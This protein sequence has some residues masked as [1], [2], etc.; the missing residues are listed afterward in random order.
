ME[1]CSHAF[2]PFDDHHAMCSR[3]GEIHYIPTDVERK[4]INRVI[5]LE[6]KS[7]Q[8]MSRDNK[9]SDEPALEHGNTLDEDVEEVEKKLIMQ[10]LE[11][12]RY[13]KT[14]AAGLLGITFRSY[15]W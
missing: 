8:I 7:E 5:E 9:E 11:D 6:E 14:Q 12:T 1:N 4:L 15:L 3:C 13:N 2:H 10:A